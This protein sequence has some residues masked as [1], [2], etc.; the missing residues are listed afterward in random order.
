MDD[1][2]EQPL[3]VSIPDPIHLQ[4][5]DGTHY[6]IADEGALAAMLGVEYV[7]A[8]RATDKGLEWLTEKRHWENVEAGAAK[9]AALKRN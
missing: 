3:A 4:A 1:Q 6:V 8:Y 5:P 9:V 2:E 7:A